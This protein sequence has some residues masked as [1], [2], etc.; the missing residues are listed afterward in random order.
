MNR[1][2]FHDNWRNAFGEPLEDALDDGLLDGF[3]IMVSIDLV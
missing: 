1:R 2:V 3:Q